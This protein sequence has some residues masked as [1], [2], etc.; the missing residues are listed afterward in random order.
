MRG[1]TGGWLLCKATGGQGRR[2]LNVVHPDSNGYTGSLVRTVSGT[3]KY[4]LFVV[5]LQ[6]ELDM[7]PLPPEAEE[8]KNMPKAQ[9]NICKV[10][11]PLQ[12]LAFHVKDC[13]ELLSSS[14]EIETGQSH[15]QIPTPQHLNSEEPVDEGRRGFSG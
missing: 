9:C 4:I 3:G 1:L 13:V 12:I 8:F 10:V 5:P 7:A 6:E 14:D 2:K 15:P 11:F